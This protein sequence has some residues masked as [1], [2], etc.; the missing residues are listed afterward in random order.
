M[1]LVSQKQFLHL[2]TRRNLSHTYWIIKNTIIRPSTFS[3][4]YSCGFLYLKPIIEGPHWFIWNLRDL[5]VLYRGVVCPLY[6]Y[7][8]HIFDDSTNRTLLEIVKSEVHLS[9]TIQLS[10]ISQISFNLKV[11]IIYHSSFAIDIVTDATFLNSLSYTLTNEK[12]SLW[13]FFPSKHIF[14]PA[15]SIRLHN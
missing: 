9:S 4:P 14:Y 11:S 6:E 15:N 5:I 2:F 3:T 1:F 13:L 8:W 10:M 7:V 12:E